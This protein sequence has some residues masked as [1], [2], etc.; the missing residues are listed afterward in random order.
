[1][2]T[3]LTIK[4]Y[5]FIIMFQ[6]PITKEVF[7]YILPSVTTKTYLFTINSLITLKTN[8]RWVFLYRINNTKDI[9]KKN[10]YVVKNF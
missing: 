1:M 4:W 5:V 3:I 10:N 8:I 9:K 7:Q 2:R 6:I